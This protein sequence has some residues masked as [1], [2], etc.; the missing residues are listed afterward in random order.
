M[1]RS[2]SSAVMR[3]ASLSFRFH[4]FC[5]RILRQLGF[6]IPPPRRGPVLPIPFLL[7]YTFSGRR[8]WSARLRGVCF[9]FHSFYTARIAAWL[10]ADVDYF[11]FHSFYKTHSQ[12]PL[13]NRDTVSQLLPIPFLLQPYFSAKGGA[14]ARDERVRR[15]LVDAIVLLVSSD[16]IPSTDR[17]GP[18]RFHSFDGA[19]PLNTRFQFHSEMRSEV[20]TSDSIPRGRGRTA[21]QFHSFYRRIS[22]IAFAAAR[23]PATVFQFHSFYRRISSLVAVDVDDAGRFLP[24]PFILQTHFQYP[25]AAA[26][27]RAGMA[28]NS[29]P[30]TD[31]PENT[32]F[33]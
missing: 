11:R 23:A 14:P 13:G 10:G 6:T 15:R 19:V 1:R 9:L 18:S 27:L 3:P 21:F 31:A 29:I 24:I 26:A 4:S 32:S 20:V 17:Q 7:H 22:S 25:D 2:A 5:R 30:S 16:S 28:S 8:R 33:R 12:A